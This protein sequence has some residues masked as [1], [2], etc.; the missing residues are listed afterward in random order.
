MRKKILCLVI[1]HVARGGAEL[2]VGLDD[3][4]HSLQEVFLCGN[5][6]TCSDGKHPCLC[7]HTANFST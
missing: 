1:S 4:V 3:L 6:S 5:F 2:G 7:T